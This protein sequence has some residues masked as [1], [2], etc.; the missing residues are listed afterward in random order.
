M[1]RKKAAIASLLMLFLVTGCTSNTLSENPPNTN[2]PSDNEKNK[3]EV[4]VPHIR[5]PT[6]FDEEVKVPV[7]EAQGLTNVEIVK[8]LCGL[9]P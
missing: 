1:T 2:T 7:N 9:T 5:R 3:E 8:K 4:K 6:R